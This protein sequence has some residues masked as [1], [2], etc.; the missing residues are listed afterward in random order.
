VNKFYFLVIII[1]TLFNLSFADEL[2]SIFPENG[3]SI[4]DHGNK[5]PKLTKGER[6]KTKSMLMKKCL[7]DDA[8][9]CLTLGMLYIFDEKNEKKGISFFQKSCQLG[10]KE[11]C[12]HFALKLSKLNPIKSQMLL[13][14]NCQLG[15]IKSCRR[16]A[17]NFN[18]QKNR[19]KAQYFYQLSCEKNDLKSCYKLAMLEPNLDKRI[20]LL[21]NNCEN[22]HLLSCRASD[23]LHQKFNAISGDR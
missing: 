17:E 8:V 21:K 10:E 5:L 1:Q 9:A 19:E 15:H 20:N 16:V 13:S 14:S 4:C 6:E 18:R 23:V 12:F 3:K 22:R 11:G 7:K 2:K